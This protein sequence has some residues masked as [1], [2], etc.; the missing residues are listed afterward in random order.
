M[1]AGDLRSFVCPGCKGRAV[2][3]T[4]LRKVAA[5]E[6]VTALWLQAVKQGRGAGPACPSC[7]QPMAVVRTDGGV[8][9]D[10]CRGCQ[11]LWF[12]ADELET[13][14]K[15][16]PSPEAQSADVPDPALHAVAR[17]DARA[18][19]RREQAETG[20]PPDDS[21]RAALAM[22]LGVPFEEGVPERRARPWMTWGLAALTAVLFWPS[23][24]DPAW[25]GR[26]AMVPEES[27][28]GLSPK[29]FIGA[30]MHEDPLHLIL[31]LHL[32]LLFADNVEDDLGLG[33][34]AG[35]V[36]AALLL[37]GVVHAALDP[38]PEYALVGSTA[39]GAAAL[40]YYTLRYPKA[41]IGVMLDFR[42]RW[43]W[44]WDPD[45][46]A[47]RWVRFPCWVGAL[48]VVG[49]LVVVTGMQLGGE[50]PGFS[51]VAGLSGIPVGALIWGLSGA[52]R[53]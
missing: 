10:V 49:L 30:L 44:T 38:F 52:K 33:G 5:K 16:A 9:I 6:Q 45:N 19:A 46:S 53:W 37:G 20:A 2:N 51:G 27:F 17:L 11:L 40:T 47:I 41:R 24:F 39:A 34:F 50:E 22:Y 42:R 18:V 36:G 12:D 1:R 7:Q 35:L 4:V 28:L 31:D 29:V 13:I 21:F 48:V 26:Y 14:A 8:E 3:V 15:P 25:V 32:L 23:L 43:G